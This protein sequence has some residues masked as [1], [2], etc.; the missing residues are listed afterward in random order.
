MSNLP[1]APW[2]PGSG[3]TPG[4]D[5]NSQLSAAYNPPNG[6]FTFNS[7][8]PTALTKPPLATDPTR[9]VTAT[10]P[11]PPSASAVRR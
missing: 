7:G 9:L 1:C 10:P 3:F 2:S 11:V 8:Y 6:T 4:T 5:A